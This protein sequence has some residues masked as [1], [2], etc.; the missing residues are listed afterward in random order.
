MGAARRHSEDDRNAVT[1]MCAATRAVRPVDELIRFVRAPDGA[2]VPDLKRQLPGRGV[3]VTA[4]RGA[5]TEAVR[6]KVFARGLKDQV[7]VS[8]DL[9]D[10]VERLL[11][12]SVQ[13]FLSMANKAGKVVTGFAKVESALAQGGVSVLLHAADAAPDGVRKLTQ[14]LRRADAGSRVRQISPLTGPEM[15]L[16]LGRPN[17]I[18]A[19][20]LT[21]SVSRAFLARADILARF[22]GDIA[23]GSG[24]PEADADGQTAE[25]DS[26]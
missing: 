21:D 9:P 8:P 16:A 1:R 7:A 14:A 19:A 4:A 20:L 6:R 12:R 22:R 15:D 26:E 5:V 13:D 3:W 11:V 18:H 10:Q 24:D 17:V 25:M 2:V 23:S